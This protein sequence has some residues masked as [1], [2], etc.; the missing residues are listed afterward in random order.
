VFRSASRANVAQE[1]KEA[2]GG[3]DKARWLGYGRG[4]EVRREHARVEGQRVAERFGVTIAPV[5][6]STRIERIVTVCE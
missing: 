1:A 4:L 3:K 2:A 6:S 5:P